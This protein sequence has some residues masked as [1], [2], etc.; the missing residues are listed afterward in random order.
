M[1]SKYQFRRHGG[2][3]LYKINKNVDVVCDTLP[4]LTY[5]GKSTKSQILKQKFEI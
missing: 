3:C 1:A 5:T 4:S 2:I